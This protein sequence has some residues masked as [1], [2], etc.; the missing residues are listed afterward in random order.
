MN[1]YQQALNGL[2]LK[3]GDDELVLGHRNSEWTGLGPLL[4]EDIA[5][6]SMAQDQIG[7]ALGLYSLLQENS[8]VDPDHLAFLR[9]AEAFR[10]CQLVEIPSQDY[11]FSLMRHFLFDTSESLRYASLRD[12]SSPQLRGLAFKV[13][14]ELKYHTLHA[15]TWILNLAEANQESHD[16]LQAALDGTLDL[17]AGIFEPLNE[18]EE[19]E[20]VGH[21]VYPGERELFGRWLDEVYGTLAKT[22]LILPEPSQLIPAFGGRQGIHTP[23]LQALL[24]EM[25]EVLRSEPQADW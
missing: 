23:Y 9:N 20:L 3:M 7:H 17:A 21:R 14:G 15:R 25:G 2:L 24:N 8:G 6:S 16:R 11:G 10:C 5:F 12:S 19:S 22:G 4:E 18:E 13:G 1:G